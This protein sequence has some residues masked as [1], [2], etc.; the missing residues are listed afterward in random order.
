MKKRNTYIG[1]IS[2][3]FFNCSAGIPGKT[4]K[5]GVKLY[6]IVVDANGT[7]DFVTV[8]GAINSVSF[9]KEK[10]KGLKSF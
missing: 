1:I 7:G 10:E 9:L 2:L 5:K 3:L 8:Q 6:D 4:E